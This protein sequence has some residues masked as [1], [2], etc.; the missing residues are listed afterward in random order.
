MYRTEI[1]KHDSMMGEGQ[2]MSEN[3]A[4]R[5]DSEVVDDWN[6]PN[7]LGFQSVNADLRAD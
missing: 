4:T 7:Q 1:G 6:Q 5:G 3:H 2:R